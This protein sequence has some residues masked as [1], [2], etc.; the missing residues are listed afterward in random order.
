MICEARSANRARGLEADERRHGPWRRLRRH[1]GKEKHYSHTGGTP[2]A[3][4]SF[5]VFPESGHVVIMLSNQRERSR[6]IAQAMTGLV[7]TRE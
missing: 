4:V 6:D 1:P 7:S 5:E 3:D 2:R